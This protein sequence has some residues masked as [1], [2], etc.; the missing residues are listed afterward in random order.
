M[1]IR[2][3]RRHRY[4][5]H[6]ECSMIDPVIRYLPEDQYEQV[7]SGVDQSGWVESHDP[8]YFDVSLYS[9]VPCR[10]GLYLS[11]GIAD[12]C[13][14]EARMMD[15][16]DYVG[17]SGPTWKQKMIN[18]GMHP[19][20]IVIVGYPKLDPLFEKISG[21]R[22]AGPLRVLYAPTHNTVPENLFSTSSYPRLVSDLATLQEKFDVR[23][24]YHPANR[25]DRQVTLD[26]LLWPDVVISD[27]G[28][29]LYEAWALNIPVVF[30]DWL[31]RQPIL[32]IFSS[33]LEGKIYREGIGY[34][35]RDLGHL[36]EL[37]YK[38]YEEGLDPRTQEF[39]EGILP[40]E[41]K[42]SSGR[43]TA[44]VLLELAT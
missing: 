30:P 40:S 4:Y 21:V 39:I 10:T 36:E 22:E 29:L 20:R 8:N 11:H 17:V 37:I 33:S 35:A 27:S 42:G 31:V 34:H 26:S 6:V 24:S 25:N 14:R 9:D 18:Q 12:K 1:K 3:R 44:E 32:S 5:P 38:A 23:S 16:F 19:S 15:R 7:V 43:K 2:F 13:Y 41:L 28:S